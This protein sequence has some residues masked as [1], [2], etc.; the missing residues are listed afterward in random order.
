MYDM[1]YIV[2]LAIATLIF[3]CLSFAFPPKGLGV[4]EAWDDGPVVGE[5]K[6]TDLTVDQ[7]KENRVYEVECLPTSTTT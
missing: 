1:S 2:N 5:T 6:T 7:E 3:C 4:A